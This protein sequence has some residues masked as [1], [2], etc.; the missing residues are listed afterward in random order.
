MRTKQN[1]NPNQKHNKKNKTN[2]SIERLKSMNKVNY[3]PSSLQSKCLTKKVE[4]STD[5]TCTRKRLL[6]K[7]CHIKKENSINYFPFQQTLV[8]HTA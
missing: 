4:D 3:I 1:R 8:L 7:D 5:H 2:L 6:T